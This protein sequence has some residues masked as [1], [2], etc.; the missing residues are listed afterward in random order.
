M[1]PLLHHLLL[2]PWTALSAL[3]PRML[4]MRNNLCNYN[5]SRITRLAEFIPLFV[6]QAIFPLSFAGT[7]CF[8]SFLLALH[9]KMYHVPVY[10]C[11]VTLYTNV[12]THTIPQHMY[13]HT[14]IHAYTRR[15]HTHTSTLTL[16]LTRSLTHL[17]AHTHKRIQ[18]MRA[19]T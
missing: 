8:F 2:F 3:G 10:V 6:E 14:N 1:Q 4:R 11:R 16:S 12:C 5:A 15:T 7:S 13:A 17:L 9:T 18:A 19:H